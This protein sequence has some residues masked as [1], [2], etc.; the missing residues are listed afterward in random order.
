MEGVRNNELRKITLLGAGGG[1]ITPERRDKRRGCC[2]SQVHE[3][4]ETHRAD[5][6][7]LP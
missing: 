2:G 7:P 3:Q 5:F 6:A 1:H 4:D